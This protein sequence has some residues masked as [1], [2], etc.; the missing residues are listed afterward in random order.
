M[1]FRVMASWVVAIITGEGEGMNIER[2]SKHR[3]LRDTSTL[4]GSQRR[5]S[6]RKGSLQKKCDTD[7]N[8][9]PVS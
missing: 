8:K 3:A 9:K 7:K 6:Q 4:W 5:G 1:Y 2:G